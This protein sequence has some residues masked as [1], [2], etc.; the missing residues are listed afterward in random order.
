[1]P[2]HLSRFQVE[3]LQGNRPR[4]RRHQ[5]R[6]TTAFER[7][8]YQIRHALANARTARQG[9]AEAGVAAAVAIE[10]HQQGGTTAGLVVRIIGKY[11]VQIGN[12]LK[13]ATVHAEQDLGR[14][15]G[16]G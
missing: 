12:R 6:V 2:L 16:Q 8:Q 13:I 1:M 7:Q 15:L 14:R 4:R 10:S 11:Q 3:P 5:Q 9:G